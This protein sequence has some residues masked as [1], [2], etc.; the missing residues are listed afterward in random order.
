[1]AE[2]APV[3]MAVHEAALHGFVDDEDDAHE[4]NVSKGAEISF[5]SFVH[6]QFQAGDPIRCAGLRHEKLTKGAL[7]LAL[8]LSML[9]GGNPVAVKAGLRDCPPLRLGWMRFVLGGLVVLAAAAFRR[10]SLRVERH[11]WAALIGLGCLFSS[12]L[13]FMNIGQ[14]HT[15]AGHA[16][17]IISAYPLWTSVLAHF[18]VPGD[19]LTRPRAL[20]A[21]VAY[22]GV[23]VVF[24]TSLR[25]D[26]GTL[27]GDGLLVVSSLLLGARQIVLSRSAQGIA[28]EKLLLAQ[29][30]VGTVS[31]LVASALFETD[32]TQYTA[33]L[34]VAL[35]YQGVVIAG[36]AFLLQMW[37]L[38]N[39]PPSRVTTVYLTQPLFGV[40]LS[41]LVL[42]E[43]VGP[44]LF[45]GALLVVTGSYFVQRH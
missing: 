16:A 18:L 33:Q 40:L 27:L 25:G 23:V 21:I 9:W 29:A 13:A 31:F 32:P 28:V 39:F 14:N 2:I 4:W 22:S 7:G 15:S 8:S 37:L 5:C 3:G 6:R 30:V 35:F 38:K 1:M 41:W 45:F 26:D 36:F 34:G 12:Q 42:G 17:V 20:G 11:E 19:R 10:Q 44:E 43:Q 24:I